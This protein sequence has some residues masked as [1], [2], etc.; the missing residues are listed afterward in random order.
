[1]RLSRCDESQRRVTEIENGCA[2]DREQRRRQAISLKRASVSA[3]FYGAAAC[4]G[5]A[6]F[7][8]AAR[9]VLM[10]PLMRR[11]RALMLVSCA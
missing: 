3:D 11:A 7:V 4:R 1:M 8:I 2:N 6:A 5:M 9:R 10:M